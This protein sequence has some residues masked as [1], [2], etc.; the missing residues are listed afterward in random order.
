[1]EEMKRKS[2]IT[3]GN[4]ALDDVK[5]FFSSMLMLLRMLYKDTLD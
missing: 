3:L 5:F 2:Q 1:M 4:Q